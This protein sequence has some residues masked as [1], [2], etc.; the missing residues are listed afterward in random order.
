MG[1][2]GETTYHAVVHLQTVCKQVQKQGVQHGVN[3]PCPK[4]ALLECF[5]RALLT[6][7]RNVGLQHHYGCQIV[8]SLT[9]MCS[10]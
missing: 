2:T 3:L 7:H 10:R 5:P 4:L 9:Q 6:A 1:A 8:A